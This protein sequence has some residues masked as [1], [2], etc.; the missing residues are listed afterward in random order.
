MGTDHAPDLRNVVKTRRRVGPV[1]KGACAGLA[2]AVASVGSIVAQDKATEDP[3]RLDYRDVYENMHY[4]QPLR[5][6]VHYTPITGQIGDPTGLIRYKGKYHLFYMFDEWSRRR[7]DN[8]NWG[9]ATSDDVRFGD[10]ADTRFS[11]IKR[12]A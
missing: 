7:R 5:P 1:M 4:D 3:Y 9:H 12:Q 6:Q 2:L 11:L 8:K 10:K